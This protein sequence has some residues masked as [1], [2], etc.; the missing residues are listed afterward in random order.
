MTHKIIQDS[1]SGPTVC[2]LF[3]GIGGLELGFHLNGFHSQLLCEIDPVASHVLKVRF[4]GIE[5]VSDVRDVSSLRN[6][7]VLCAGFP[8]QNLSSS[9]NKIGI[10][11][12]QSSLVDEIFR[13]LE[14]NHPKWVVIE[15]VRFMLHLNQGEAMR[16]I[17]DNFEQLGYN[18]AYRVIDSQSFGV[19]QRRHRV[20]FIASRTEDPRNVILSDDSI[21]PEALK[22]LTIEEPIGFYWTEG[23][24]AAGLNR[25]AIPPLK[26]GSTIGIPSPP[27]I[28]FPDGLVGTP[29]IR[30]AERVQGFHENWTK[31]AE[32]V[33][34]PSIRWRLLGNSVTVNVSEWIAQKILRP[35]PY[36]ASK[37]RPLDKKW[38]M[39]AWSIDKQRHESFSSDWPFNSRMAQISDF[40]RHPIKPLSVRATNGFLSRA[41]KGNL[42]YPKGFLEILSNHSGSK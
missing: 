22:D 10:S 16:R 19:P 12:T 15:N 14:S 17:V 5:L 29:D 38:P 18:W 26:A 41:Y 30:D 23:A 34:K 35:I 28:C 13:L 6:A 11:G 1:Q 24:Y 8:C 25:N 3:S 39:A 40:L 33:A 4:P 7:D 36:D 42:K 37:D 2:G 32:E 27:A 20:Y 21:R 9:G 31:P